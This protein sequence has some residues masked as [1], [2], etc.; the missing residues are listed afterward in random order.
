MQ[1]LIAESFGGKD[2]PV[3]TLLQALVDVGVEPLVDP[4]RVKDVPTEGV[5][6]VVHGDIM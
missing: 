5:Y 6:Q 3:D 1:V 4:L 2:E